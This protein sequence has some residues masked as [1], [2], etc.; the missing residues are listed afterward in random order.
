M[1]VNKILRIAAVL[2]LCAGAKLHAAPINF[3]GDLTNAYG[4]F[5]V[6]KRPEMPDKIAIVEHAHFTPDV[7]NGIKG[8]SST[9]GGD[10]DYTLR[11]IPNHHRALAT[12][13][14]VALRDHA[15][16]IVGMRYPVECWFNR[17]VRFAA[18]D[19]A[20]YATYGSY[21]FSL[22]QISRAGDMF[23]QGLAYEP[24]NITLNYNLGLVYFKQQ[25]YDKAKVYAKK[26]YAAGY[27]LPGLKNKLIEVHQWDETP[28][29]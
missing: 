5:D 19:P 3:C 22:G 14:A 9:L 2:A 23:K 8:S 24:D 12:V 4:P 21:L 13:A 7:E 11:A 25:N 20:V 29:H 15:V 6:R 1:I 17:A 28:A 27:P 10:L 18:D 16:Q 26:A